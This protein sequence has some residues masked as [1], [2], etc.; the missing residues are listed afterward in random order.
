MITEVVEGELWR[1]PRPGY[2]GEGGGPV[3][4]P[5]VDE[6]I[7]QAKTL[8]IKSII[9]LLAEDQLHMY[10]QLPSDL[11]SYYRSA[12]FIVEHVPAHDYQSPPLAPDQLEAIWDA[13]QSLPKPLVVHCSAGIDRTGSAVEY[14]ERKLGHT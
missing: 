6:W 12:G 5:A 3:P 7:Q 8:T 9:C 11:V 14:I 13:Y 10:D 4:T 2:L 1:S